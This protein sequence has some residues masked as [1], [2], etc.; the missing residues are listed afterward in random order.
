MH[1]H[2]RRSVGIAEPSIGDPLRWLLG[3]RIVA[4]VPALKALDHPLL[5]RPLSHEYD[6]TVV[7]PFLG[8]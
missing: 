2:V 5:E 7:V 4:V 1:D 6:H 3:W 8:R